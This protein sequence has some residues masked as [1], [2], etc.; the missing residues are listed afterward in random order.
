MKKKLFSLIFIA[1][2]FTCGAN[3]QSVEKSGTKPES[4]EKIAN[5]KA[6]KENV[7]PKSNEGKSDKKADE[8]APAPRSENAS[9]AATS[10][11][12]NKTEAKPA[13]P[14]K[15]PNQGKAKANADTPGVETAPIPANNKKTE[16]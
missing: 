1:G 12:D 4:K 2:L 11:S 6:E 10:A 14:A 5:D 15:A 3:A 9:P 8:S 7:A 13:K 16:K